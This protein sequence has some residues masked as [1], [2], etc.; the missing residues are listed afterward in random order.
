MQIS[1]HLLSMSKEKAEPIQTDFRQE[2]GCILDRSPI[3]PRAGGNSHTQAKHSKTKYSSS[4]PES[5]CCDVTVL[6]NNLPCYTKCSNY[7]R[8]L[9]Y[10]YSLWIQ[11]LFMGALAMQCVWQTVVHNSPAHTLLQS[12]LKLCDGDEMKRQE[13]VQISV[14]LCV[15]VPVCVR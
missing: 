15:C 11:Y 1:I 9:Q 14:Y 8:T 13:R 7:H 12:S 10:K 2:T 3:H 5:S 6:T 4:Q